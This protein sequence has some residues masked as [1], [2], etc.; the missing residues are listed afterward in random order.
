MPGGC[1]KL[2]FMMML[3]SSSTSMDLFAAV[4]PLPVALRVPAAP[5]GVR[6]R[7]SFTGSNAAAFQDF[8][9]MKR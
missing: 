5:P 1:C 8:C 2:L 9:A 6:P 3:H 7:L 4:A